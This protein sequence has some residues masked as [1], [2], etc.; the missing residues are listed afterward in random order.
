MPVCRRTPPA[1]RAENDHLIKNSF[2][3]TSQGG[4]DGVLERVFSRLDAHEGR[5]SGAGR[6]CVEFG[7]WD[8]KHLSNTW[9]LLH[10]E[11][12]RGVLIEADTD[13]FLEMQ[14]MYAPF[15][16]VACVNQFVTFEGPD[17]LEAILARHEVPRD[18]DLVSID[19]DGADYHIWDSLRTYAPKVVVIEFNPTIPNNVV[20]IQDKDMSVYQGS[21]LAALIELGKTKGYEL[22]S[23]T[24]FNGV[25][26]QR[27]LYDL[28]GI[29]DNAID[30]MHDVS[31]GTEFFQLYDGTLKITGVKKLLW[32]KQPILEKD[33]QVLPPSERRFPLSPP[34]A[35]LEAAIAAADAHFAT[36][37]TPAAYFLDLAQQWSLHITYPH[38]DLQRLAGFALAR[39][40]DEGAMAAAVFEIY[41]DHAR[42]LFTKNEPSSAIPWLEEALYLRA[43]LAVQRAPVMALLGE[44]YI[45]CHEYA[46]AELW[47]QTAHALDPAA[48]TTLK[49]LAKLY[50]KQGDAARTEAVVRQLKAL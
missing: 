48:K 20:F 47:L 8:G 32:K 42:A 14:A 31:M 11:G 38:P 9:K 24:T 50:T 30:K 45:R 40:A 43:S 1:K 28:F 36:E 35:T 16:G 2:N 13:R 44:A 23:T 21:S 37:A 34:S 25:F 5:S 33:L 4:E 15:P 22:V 27:E 29:A 26:V 10:E 39:A 41:L 17:S 7:A 18:V 3:V 12:W 49:S 6:W 19:I 46:K